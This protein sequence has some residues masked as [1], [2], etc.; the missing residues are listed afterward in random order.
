M[1]VQERTDEDVDDERTLQAGKQP[2]SRGV[3]SSSVPYARRAEYAQSRVYD[4]KGR[5]S[6]MQ[7]DPGTRAESCGVESGGTDDASSAQQGVLGAGPFVRSPH[8]PRAPTPRMADLIF[9][10]SRLPLLGDGVRAPNA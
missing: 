7:R 9:S 2:T 6:Q 8:S 5:A 3:H 10:L 1:C 4:A